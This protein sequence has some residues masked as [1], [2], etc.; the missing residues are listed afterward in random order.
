MT[1]TGCSRRWSFNLAMCTLKME[2]R[3]IRTTRSPLG[4]PHGPGLGALRLGGDPLARHKDGSTLWSGR[5]R[6]RDSAGAGGGLAEQ[7][8]RQEGEGEELKR[9]CRPRQMRL[10]GARDEPLAAGRCKPDLGRGAHRR[11]EVDGA[12]IN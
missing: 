1:F 5:R 3:A 4:Q 11:W 6:R 9:G 7:E 8:Q 2:R 10:P 12:K